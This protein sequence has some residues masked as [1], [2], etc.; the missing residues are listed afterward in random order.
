[1]WWYLHSHLIQIPIGWLRSL[2]F[3]IC[4]L[5]WLSVLS[6][7]DYLKLWQFK[8]PFSFARSLWLF[9]SYTHIHTPVIFMSFC[10]I[11]F[12]V[13][14]SISLVMV[15]PLHN[16]YEERRKE[17][18][19]HS[20]NNPPLLKTLSGTFPRRLNFTKVS[21]HLQVFISF[22]HISRCN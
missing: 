4:F 20:S 16:L 19:S 15:A 22:Y 12:S 8:R 13:C 17:Y 5:M 1:M 11:K 14:I 7:P 2:H 6:L 10:Q 21:Y 3:T 18:W 9:W